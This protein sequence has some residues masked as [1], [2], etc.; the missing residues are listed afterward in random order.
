MH[1]KPIAI[2][3]TIAGTTVTTALAA[4][5][6]Q[7]RAS[8]V[9]ASD[10]NVQCVHSDRGWIFDTSGPCKNFV[11][12]SEIRI[13]ESFQTA[14]KKISINV[15]SVTV[16]DKDLLPVGRKGQKTCMAASAPSEI[17]TYSDHESEYHQGTW[18]YIRDCE[19]LE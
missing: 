1:L 11:P 9:R 5:L 6:Q 14:G 2:A 18:L 8:W 3:F 15:I 4:E 16:H 17:P 19:P 10:G 7:Y 12:P 13:G